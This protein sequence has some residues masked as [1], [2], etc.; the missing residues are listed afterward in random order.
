M[1][2]PTLTPPRRK[3]PRSVFCFALAVLYLGAVN[4]IRARLAL[5]GESFVAS[6]PLTMPLPYLA[7]SAMVWGSVFCIAA[8]GVWRLWPWAR[9]LTLGAIVIYQL[10][11]WIN[12]FLF[13][14]S[15]YARQVWP[16]QAGVSAA[17]IILVWGFLFLPAVRHFYSKH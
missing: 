7:A 3:R 9:K 13:D 4:L 14:T 17:W 8:F 5:R 12:H 1:T 10:H 6:L 2:T 11:I 15:D 16:F